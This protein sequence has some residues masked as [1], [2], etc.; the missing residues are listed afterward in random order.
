MSRKVLNFLVTKI[1]MSKLGLAQLGKFQL[2]F[3]T[4]NWYQK[5]DQQFGVK[6]QLKKISKQNRK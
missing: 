1:E 5:H 3:I 4:S 2:K 6:S